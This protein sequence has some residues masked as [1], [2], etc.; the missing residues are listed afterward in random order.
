MNF[1]N[2]IALTAVVLLIVSIL[3]AMLVLSATCIIKVTQKFRA[4]V[5]IVAALDLLLDFGSIEN[6]GHSGAA[7]YMEWYST[8]GLMLILVWLYL[9]VLRFFFFYY[10][11]LIR[12]RSSVENV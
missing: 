10:V 6:G 5:I 8:I 9:E 2:S 4:V 12:S 1:G 7:K 11:I 3:F